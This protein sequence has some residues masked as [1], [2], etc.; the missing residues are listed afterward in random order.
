MRQVQKAE[1]VNSQM[2]CITGST[3]SN[4]NIVMLYIKNVPQDHQRSITVVATKTQNTLQVNAAILAGASFHRPVTIN[5]NYT[6]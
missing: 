4:D 6:K 3:E 1:N 2:K 5:I